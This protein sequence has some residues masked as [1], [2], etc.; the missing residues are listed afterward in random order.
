[1]NNNT[2]STQS[3]PPTKNS[4]KSPARRKATENSGGIN[5]GETKEEKKPT[6]ESSPLTQM[7]EMIFTD[8]ALVIPTSDGIISFNLE[9]KN[10]FSINDPTLDRGD[11][12]RIFA[13]LKLPEELFPDGYKNAYGKIERWFP[14]YR[15][16]GTNSGRKGGWHPFFGGMARSSAPSTNGMH[17]F[18]QGFI[19][20]ALKDPTMTV[21]LEPKDREWL[22]KININNLHLNAWMMKCKYLERLQFHIQ[23]PP[24]KTENLNNEEKKILTER[25]KNMHLTLVSKNAL[26]GKLNYK[27]PSPERILQ[28]NGPS[29]PAPASYLCNNFFNLVNDTMN[30]TEIIKFDETKEKILITIVKSNQKFTLNNMMNPPHQQL[31][32]NNSLG[33]HNIFGMN[34]NRQSPDPEIENIINFINKYKKS[35]HNYLA[36]TEGKSKKDS[37][38]VIKIVLEVLIDR[39]H[40][41]TI[42]EI[43]EKLTTDPE[44]IRTMRD[45]KSNNSLI[46]Q[47]GRRKS[48]RRNKRKTKIKKKLNK[49]RRKSRRRKKKLN[50][51]RRKSRKKNF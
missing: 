34:L 21:D 31:L 5:S 51:R 39:Q 18:L 32:I 30:N 29:S 37:D 45:S 9:L 38:D 26:K 36:V 2:P 22:E 3:P 14:I 13:L 28:S 12:I 42:D 33:N 20:F 17:R 19:D 24:F 10:M 43:F 41:H 6:L 46:N 7:P 27:H 15:S 47:G 44:F 50:K 11:A 25:F 23:S 8:E 49:R 16:S 4:P 40:L 48:R 35:V 1:M